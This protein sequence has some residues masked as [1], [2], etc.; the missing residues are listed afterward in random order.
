MENKPNAPKIDWLCSEDD[1][2]RPSFFQRLSDNLFVP[3]G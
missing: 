3:F 1:D 2:L